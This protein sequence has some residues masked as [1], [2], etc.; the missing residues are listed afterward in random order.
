M[1]QYLIG[2]I[3]SIS[4]R[5]WR[6]D[7]T[8]WLPDPSNCY[9][10]KSA[11]DFLSEASNLGTTSLY[12]KVCNKFVPLRVAIFAW[13]TIQGRILSKE[14]L[15]KREIL[16]NGALTC[17]GGC[18]AIEST[19]HLFFECPIAFKVWS[20]IFRWL[21]VISISHNDSIFQF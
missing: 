4:F 14:N 5:D 3:R 2:E 18:G 9:S 16:S 10:V 17:E 20:D 6:R 7:R 13:Q 8:V 15:F 12:K 19:S 1:L 11:Y 21:G